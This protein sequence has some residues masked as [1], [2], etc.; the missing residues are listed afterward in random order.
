MNARFIVAV[1]ASALAL[2]SGAA[3]AGI[4]ILEEASPITRKGLEAVV[5]E[6]S[7]EVMASV[8]YTKVGSEWVVDECASDVAETAML[9]EAPFKGEI[10]AWSFVTA[11]CNGNGIADAI[12]IATGAADWDVDGTPDACEYK[13]GDLNLNGTI[14]NQD[15]SILLGWWGVSNPLYGDLN[16]DNKVDGEDLG[17]LLGRWGAVVF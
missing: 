16:G 8:V 7:D 13:I 17:T 12:D 6:C 14:D 1:G 2:A 11:D 5:E 3:V 10:E 9:E 4:E 15:V